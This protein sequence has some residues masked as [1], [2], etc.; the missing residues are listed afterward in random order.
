MAYEVVPL[1]QH[2]P[3][4]PR[5]MRLGLIG[6]LFAA[7]GLWSL[8]FASLRLGGGDAWRFLL[9]GSGLAVSGGLLSF[10][11]TTL[12]LQHRRKKSESAVTLWYWRIGMLCLIAGV[13][14]APFALMGEGASPWMEIAAAWVLVGFAV[15]VIN[16]MLYKIVPFLLWLHLTIAFQAQGRSRREVPG[17]KT[18]LPEGPARLQFALH[19]LG[20]TLL[21]AALAQPG[22]L[23]AEAAALVLG[24]SFG[25][26]GGNLVFAL[27]RYRKKRDSRPS[28]AG[29]DPGGSEG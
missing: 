29:G 11:L 22:E 21:C 5:W 6:G 24:A 15:S 9:W 17:V 23:L 8:A 19:L 10:A 7:L 26:L 20:L 27:W 16:G 2:T 28:P 3:S 4:Y 25:L 13:V 18:F 14:G 1:F 12:W